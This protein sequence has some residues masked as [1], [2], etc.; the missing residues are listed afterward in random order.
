MLKSN[1]SYYINNH[2]DYSKENFEIDRIN[3]DIVSISTIFGNDFVPKIETINVK[4]GFQ[5]IMDAYLKTL[6][7]LKDKGCFLVKKS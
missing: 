6:I 1:I 3:R 4:K 2:P 5:S 7:E